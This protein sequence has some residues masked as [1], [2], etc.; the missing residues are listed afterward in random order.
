MKKRCESREKKLSCCDWGRK[1]GRPQAVRGWQFN[2][3][4]GA[5]TLSHVVAWGS[6]GPA[7]FVSRDGLAIHRSFVAV[8]ERLG[9][10]AWDK[11]RRV[12]M[13]MR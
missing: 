2:V 6:F 7:H 8:E 4:P 13:R 1:M 9:G 5:K 10:R 12:G 3:E 11:N